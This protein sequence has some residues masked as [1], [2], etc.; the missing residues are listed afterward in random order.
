MDGEV[1]LEG[2]VANLQWWVPCSPENRCSR[3]AEL[4]TTNWFGGQ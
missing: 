1:G 2:H 3:I 4:A